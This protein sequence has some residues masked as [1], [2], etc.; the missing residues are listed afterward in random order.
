MLWKTLLMPATP[1]QLSQCDD[2]AN[3]KDGLFHGKQFCE[4]QDFK[5][6]GTLAK[7]FNSARFCHL[8]HVLAALTPHGFK[9]PRQ[10]PCDHSL[11]C[12]GTPMI[13]LRA[14]SVSM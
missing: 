5:P 1:A 6:L 8:P 4:N 13:T 14:E 9:S 11:F 3:A 10:D 2:E 7:F 12:K